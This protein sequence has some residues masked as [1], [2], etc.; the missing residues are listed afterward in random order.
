VIAGYDQGSWVSRPGERFHYSVSA[1]PL[2]RYLIGRV[3]GQSYAEYMRENIF[4]PLGM[5]G[6][7]FSADEFAERHAIPYTRIDGENIELPVWNGKGFFMHTTAE[8]MAR[9]MLAIVTE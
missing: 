1:F 3:A 6:S 5:T 4:L 8:D 9:F 7:G 2:L